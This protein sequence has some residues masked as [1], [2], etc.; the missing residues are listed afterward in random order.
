MGFRDEEDHEPVVRKRTQE[1]HPWAGDRRTGGGPDGTEEGKLLDDVFM[2]G[3]VLD[4]PVFGRR[5]QEFLSKSFEASYEP[6]TWKAIRAPHPAFF[7][8]LREQVHTHL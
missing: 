2:Y 7:R 8:L 1:R 5:G 6:N 4:L 3:N